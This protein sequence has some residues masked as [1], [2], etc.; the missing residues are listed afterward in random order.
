M[1]RPGHSLITKAKIAQPP[2]QTIASTSSSAESGLSNSVLSTAGVGNSGLLSLQL[3]RANPLS[4]GISA[5]RPTRSNP[6][7][8]RHKDVFDVL[9]QKVAHP[10]NRPIRTMG[11]H[12]ANFQDM[13]SWIE[14]CE[15]A[16]KEVVCYDSWERFFS[17]DC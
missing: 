2:R 6:F 9:C 11:D 13:L 16:L 10:G 14:K 4:E 8:E 5:S 1:K 12:L 15:K 17:D 7:M 3:Q